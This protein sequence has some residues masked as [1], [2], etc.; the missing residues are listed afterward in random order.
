MAGASGGCPL[1]SVNEPSL[2]SQDLET[3][4]P[5]DFMAKLSGGAGGGGGADGQG[6]G[7]GP[8]IQTAE[9]RSMLQEWS[10]LHE[11]NQQSISFSGSGMPSASGTPCH[12]GGHVS[13]DTSESSPC[14]SSGNNEDLGNYLDPRGRW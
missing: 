4:L 13:V 5:Q 7:V 1:D 12:G 6:G 11:A 14:I 2:F 3:S 10:K 8:G 9:Y